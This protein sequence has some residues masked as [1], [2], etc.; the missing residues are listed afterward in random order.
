MDFTLSNLNMCCCLKK[1]NCLLS[2]I[3]LELY[4]CNYFQKKLSL[5]TAFTVSYKLTTQYT[6]ILY[7]R[8]HTLVVL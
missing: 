7:M 3:K 4:C 5:P 6:V 2:K 8:K 1:Y